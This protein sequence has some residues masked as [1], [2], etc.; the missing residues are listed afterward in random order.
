MYHICVF[1]DLINNAI[2]NHR[3]FWRK[4][5][6]HF[7]K[8]SWWLQTASP[9]T[10]PE[11]FYLPIFSCVHRALTV[12]SPCAHRAFT[13]ALRSRLLFTKRSPCAHSSFSVHFSF[14]LFSFIFI[15][16][17]NVKGS[18]F[19]SH[20]KMGIDRVGKYRK[21]LKISPQKL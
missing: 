16:N 14:S 15:L 3:I 20:K 17:S 9:N 12:R 2:N 11:T 21:K 6:L 5:M 7:S 8:I 10:V 4:K 19:T 13:C 18:A 1:I